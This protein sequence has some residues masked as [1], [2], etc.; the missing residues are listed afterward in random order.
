MNSQ[1][2]NRTERQTHRHTD[3]QVRPKALPSEFLV[4][5][6]IKRSMKNE[7]QKTKHKVQINTI[8]VY[9]FNKQ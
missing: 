5:N 2:T 3:R 9:K 7:Y 4:D 6:I 8:A 1:R